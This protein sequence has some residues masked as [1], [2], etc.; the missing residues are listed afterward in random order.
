[1]FVCI[2][3]TNDASGSKF[4]GH[5]T[6]ED[7][8]QWLMTQPSV[9]KLYLQSSGITDDLIRHLE[10]VHGLTEL[11]IS[12]TKVSDNGLDRLSRMPRVSRLHANGLKLSNRAIKQFC[13]N[14]RCHT[15]SIISTGI[16]RLEGLT[17]QSG[18]EEL[19]LQDNPI[20][21]AGLSCL[22]DVDSIKVLHVSNTMVSDIT[23]GL[24]QNS[25]CLVEIGI[26]DT[27]VTENGVID[28][29]KGHPAIQI[30]DVGKLP[31]TDKIGA[32]FSALRELKEVSLAFSNISDTTVAK[33]RANR[34]LTT[35][36]LSHCKNVSGKT[37][38][39][40]ANLENLTFLDLE[41]TGVSDKTLPELARLARI[42]TLNLNNT[43]I[44]D[45]GL[46]SLAGMSDLRV[47]S[48]SGCN[49]TERGV[50]AF[51]RKLPDCHVYR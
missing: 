7:V 3:Q 34:E 39:S 26:A 13:L 47:L 9:G 5:A 40:L 35:V 51:K 22:K 28:L 45:D 24:L 8:R 43:S 50:V 49:I 17:K 29:I 42:E 20:A 36:S 14:R 25:R 2:G 4:L 1:M 30:L 18:L 23:I 27:A 41:R 44:S 48:V 38:A 32:H 46:H 37:L 19:Y 15:L 6:F 12:Y 33:L 31:V 16:S 10:S 21:D 11:D